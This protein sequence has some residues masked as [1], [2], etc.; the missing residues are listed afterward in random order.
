MN[1]TLNDR[2]FTYEAI[3]PLKTMMGHP[4]IDA[5]LIPVGMIMLIENVAGDVYRIR[6]EKFGEG[7]TFTH[8]TGVTI[9]EWLLVE[10]EIIEPV[11]NMAKVRALFRKQ[12]AKEDATTPHKWGATHYKTDG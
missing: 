3:T 6:A 11:D 12:W 1:M 4:V 5:S 7:F 8:I 9:R 10:P 2:I